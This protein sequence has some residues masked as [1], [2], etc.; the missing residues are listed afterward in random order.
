MPP[1]PTEVFEEHLADAEAL[2]KFARGLRTGRL[3][4][5]RVERREA[6]RQIWRMS[7]KDAEQLDRAESSHLHVVIKPGSP[8]SRDD[9]TEEALRPLLRQAIVAISAALETWV[10]DRAAVYVGEAIRTPPPRLSRV[11]MDLRSVLEIEAGYKRRGWGYREVLINHLQEQ[12]SPS[13]FKVA[14][15]FLLVGRKVSWPAIDKARDVERGTTEAE[16]DALYAR[17]NQVAHAADRVGRSRRA[18]T[19]EE[20][21]A[22]ISSARSIVT[23]IDAHLET[24]EPQT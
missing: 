15:V 2:L 20:I 13:S 17:R 3:K 5:M 14:Q 16:L 11:P 18:I 8:F 12:A 19:P 21:E 1:I 23:T 9:F 6:F 10:A 7:A 22:W 4:R 24:L